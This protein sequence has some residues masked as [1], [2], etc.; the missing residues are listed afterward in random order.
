VTFT[1]TVKFDSVVPLATEKLT[2]TF[3]VKLE[4]HQVAWALP[5]LSKEKNS[6]PMT[7]R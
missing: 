2:G 5:R 1:G 7:V 4:F 6:M 3:Q